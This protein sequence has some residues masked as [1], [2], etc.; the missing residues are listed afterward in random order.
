MKPKNA[1]AVTDKLQEVLNR[2]ERAKARCVD[3][4]TSGLD[5]FTNHIVG[6]V[7]TFGPKPQDSYY[8]PFR[9]YGTGNIGGQPGP[10]TPDGYWF[11]PKRTNQPHP[12]EARLLKLLDQQGTLLFGHN[13]AFDLKFMWQMGMQNLL[14][15]IE[16][17]S[18][19]EPLLDGFGGRYSLEACANRWKVEAKKSQMIYDHIAKKFGV[20]P[21]KTA[22]AHYWRLDGD[23]PM[24]VEYA[25]GDGTSTWQL[26]DK[27]MVEI[28]NQCLG[29]VH[30]IESRLIPVLVRMSMT[31][32]KIDDKK[33]NATIKDIGTEIKDLLKDFPENFNAKSPLAV[34]AWMEQHKHTD[35]PTTA[36]RE[37]KQPDGSKKRIP[38]P[39][40]PEIW[41]EKYPAGQ[42]IVD[43]RKL[44]TLES[45]LTTLRDS[46]VKSDGRVHCNFN[47][48]KSDDFGT[49]TGR[50][51]ASDPNLQ[52]ASKHNKKIGRKHRCV[53]VA[54]DGKVW[55][56]ADFSQ[57]ERR[58]LAYYSRCKALI[59]GYNANPPVDAH[60]SASMAANR[61]WPNMTPDERKAYR[62]NIGKRINQ[63][64]I[65][66]GGKGVL[67]DKY[68]IPAAEVDKVWS[69]YFR[70]MPE[71]KRLQNESS[72]IFRRRGYVVSLLGRR[73][74]LERPD[75][76]Y[77]SVNRLLQCGN[78]DAIKLKLVQIDDYLKAHGRPVD[79]LN[80]VH[81]AIDFQFE[82]KNRS[83]YEECLRIMTDF[84]K[85]PIVLDIPIVVDSG[86]GRDWAE[87][88]F[89]PEKKK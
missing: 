27:Q 57:M 29:R 61:N 9:H 72:T 68:K 89:G 16:D 49:V 18:I 33:L 66:G 8:L 80:N 67:V 81:D 4:E 41:L 64:I 14:P 42:K 47:Q 84:S 44:R 46:H 11:K 28:A 31:G 30:D 34:K 62:D 7:V 12:G 6:Y 76:S 88:T 51:S 25:E 24:A 5:P 17:T 71:I 65:T 40:F 70:A 63:T 22:M 19:N 3:V 50:L 55:G 86:E 53:F 23:D 79:L 21:D 36:G 43:I 56:S 20:K 77:T 32:I 60:T 74:R 48:M 13:I 10:S 1:P 37:V 2:L 52:A 85:G 15:R 45:T 69:D 38:A 35:W 59:D 58:L 87:A 54:D 39:S 78:A 26:R 83:H 82:E 75:L 73:A